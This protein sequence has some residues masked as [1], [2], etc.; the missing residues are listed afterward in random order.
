MNS[1]TVEYV[2]ELCFYA[3]RLASESKYRDDFDEVAELVDEVKASLITESV[4][5]TIKMPVNFKH[6]LLEKF[7]PDNM[8]FGWL[9]PA[10][11]EFDTKNI[12]VIA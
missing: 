7:L 12:R 11:V 6:T 10:F 4:V 8:K 2:N 5:F 9:K 3:L 1:E